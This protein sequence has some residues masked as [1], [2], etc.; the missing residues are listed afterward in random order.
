MTATEPLSARVRRALVSSD[1]GSI[2]SRMRARRWEL[3]MATFPDLEKMRVLDL[4][5]RVGTWTSSEVRP[6][7]VTVV[8]LERQTAEP[9]G[10]ITTRVG[11]ACALPPEIAVADYD[12]VFCNSVI[13]HVG[14]H[15]Q[16]LAL[17]E[18]VRDAAPRYWVQTPYRY[19]PIEPHWVFP[20]FQFLPV[21]ARTLITRTWR[22]GNRHLPWDET[23][24]AVET[25]LGVELLSATEMRHYFP[26]ARIL[27]EKLAGLVKSLIAVR[28]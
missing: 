8:N 22:T 18:T 28:S 14:G 5:G 17:A 11:N 10:W 9:P 24:A 3:F 12:L 13:E 21:Q 1:P 6:E 16:R 26:D 7:A 2:S 25:V 15:V 27:H 19:F 4:G 23:D 20:A